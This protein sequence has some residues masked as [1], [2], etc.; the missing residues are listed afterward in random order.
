M[1]DS[2]YNSEKDPHT[3][4]RYFFRVIYILRM[5]PFQISDSLITSV[6]SCFVNTLLLTC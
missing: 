2:G 3:V 5:L 1:C 4:G 6:L